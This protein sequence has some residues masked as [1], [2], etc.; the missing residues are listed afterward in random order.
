MTNFFKKLLKVE[1][2][3][4]SIQLKKILKETDYSFLRHLLSQYKESN[5]SEKSILDF[6][7]VLIRETQNE[8]Y[9]K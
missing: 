9:N 5:I 6:I 3:Q 1:L 8:N 7:A 2:S 4:E